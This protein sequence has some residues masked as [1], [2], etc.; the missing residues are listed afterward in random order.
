MKLEEAIRSKDFDSVLIALANGEKLPSDMHLQTK[1]SLY[2]ILIEAKQYDILQLFVQ[3]QIIETDIYEYENFDDSFFYALFNYRKIDDELIEFFDSFIGHFSNLND[4]IKGYTLLSYAFIKGAQVG[5]INTLINA[6]CEV[7]FRNNEDE[8]IIHQLVKSTESV[9]GMS[10][11]DCKDLFNQYVSLLVGNGV[12]VDSVN[13]K[14]ET[15]L[16]SALRFRKINFLT[17]LLE[18]GANPAHVDADGNNGFYYAIIWNHDLDVYPKLCE[19]ATPALNVLNGVGQ[20][21][22]FNYVAELNYDS[23]ETNQAII[24]QLINDGA[25]VYKFCNRYGEQKTTL[26]MAA[27][28]SVE[29]LEAIL[30]TGVVDLNAQDSNGNTLL[31]KV[32]A[33]NVNEDHDKAKETLSFY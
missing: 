15:S 26:D 31:H 27:G 14:N 8:D 2:E 3:N 19:Y 28:K 22:L 11:E 32:C 7:N 13:V 20:T 6:G 17:V 24:K 21:T 1:A 16:I 25:D 30:E 33:H 9:Y 29:I 12:E 23:L 5:L 4:E 10:T 18:N